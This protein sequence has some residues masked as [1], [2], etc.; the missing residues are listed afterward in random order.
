[1]RSKWGPS[2][3]PMSSNSGEPE[4]SNP[5]ARDLL[6]CPT[7][8]AANGSPQKPIFGPLDSLPLPGL[9]IWTHWSL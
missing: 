1:M 9:L 5:T 3:H 2:S 6:R 8:L 7:L 4:I